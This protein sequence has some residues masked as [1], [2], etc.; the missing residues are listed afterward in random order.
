MMFFLFIPEMGKKFYCNSIKTQVGKLRKKG[1]IGNDDTEKADFR[2]GEKIGKHQSRDHETEQG[3]RIR[4]NCA[5]KALFKY[6][7]HSLNYSVL[8]FSFSKYISP[9]LIA[10][11]F[12]HLFASNTGGNP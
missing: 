6:K 11:S 8:I 4:I 1:T 5:L 10:E 3:T 9:A 12:P 7:S 2:S